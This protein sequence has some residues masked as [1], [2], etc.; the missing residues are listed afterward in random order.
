MQV[1]VDNLSMSDE[2]RQQLVDFD[3]TAEEIAEVVQASMSGL[4]PTI[5]RGIKRIPT[6]PIFRATIRQNASKSGKYIVEQLRHCA[7]GNESV[8]G[9]SRRMI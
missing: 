1:K 9:G 7:S 5:G 8:D 3:V 6:L 2:V 4:L